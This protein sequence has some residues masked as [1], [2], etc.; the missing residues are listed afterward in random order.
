[1]ERIHKDHQC[2][3]LPDWDCL[4]EHSELTSSVPVWVAAGDPG[5]EF[6]PF[7]ATLLLIPLPWERLSKPASP[8]QQIPGSSVPGPHGV[9][10]SGSQCC[11]CLSLWRHR[12]PGERQAEETNDKNGSVTWFTKEEEQESKDQAADLS[13]GRPG[14]LSLYLKIMY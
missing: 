1:M 12:A 8:G 9:T 10:D 2:S 3:S 13:N 5:M 14:L 4:R 11:T 6:N 7:A